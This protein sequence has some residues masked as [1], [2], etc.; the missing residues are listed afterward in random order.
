MMS[1]LVLL[2]H[3]VNIYSL[4]AIA[5]S[6]LDPSIPINYKLPFNLI[7][8]KDNFNFVKDCI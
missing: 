5:Q 7:F 2:I 4:V 6:R 1:R 3:F 8:V